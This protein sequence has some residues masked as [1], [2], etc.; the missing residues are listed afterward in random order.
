MSPLAIAK[1]VSGNAKLGD[2]ATTHAAQASC[3]TECVFRDGGGCYAE[4]GRQGK[5]VT[6]PLNRDASMH[7]ATALDVAMAE[8]QA[9]D[10][11]EVIPGRPMRLHTVGDCP[12]DACAQIVGHAARRYVDRGGGPVWTY[13]H[14]WR[15]VAR[16]SWK[17][18]H[19]FASCE[20]G[21]DVRYARSRGY[22]TAIVVEE[23]PSDKRFSLKE[24]GS[25]VQSGT[26][27][28]APA[29]LDNPG[30]VTADLGGSPPL[31]VIPCPAQTR[32][33]TCTDCRLCFDAEARFGAGVTIGF[34]LHGI[35]YAIRAAR[36][37]L[38]HPDHPDRRLPSLERIRII[39]DRYLRVE[40]REPT[41]KEVAEM[42][43]LNT[44]SVAQW[45][46]YLRGEIEHPAETR[47]KRRALR[48]VS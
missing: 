30:F 7:Q 13:T 38:Q 37:A 9:I 19:V 10:D 26:D 17:D 6:E 43:D 22:A 35:P 47:R 16:R 29:D 2:A 1:S 24:T 4:S 31:P 14:A 28:S 25:G 15:T 8:A 39:R 45:L 41:V 12:D 46:Q 33:R 36:L 27:G 42:I 3:P 20:T 21:H 32:H 11:M 40:K 5:F 48:V 18:I 23:F 44:S 34:E